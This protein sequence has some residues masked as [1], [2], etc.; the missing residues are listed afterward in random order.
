VRLQLP[1]A[2]WVALISSGAL[3][4]GSPAGLWKT[5]DDEGRQEKALVRIVEGNGVLTGRIE[6]LLDPADGR[7]P[8]CERCTDE[9]RG[10]P[11]LGMT[12]LRDLRKTADADGWDGGDI[13][14]PD[15]GRIYRARLRLRDGGRRLEV[16]GYVGLPLLGRSQT[17][18]RME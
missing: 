7:D 11:V 3:A 1:V 6:R 5:Y 10:R 9:R 12:I 2:A 18:L 16:R 4:Q 17:W 13:L 15:D 14:D 8:V